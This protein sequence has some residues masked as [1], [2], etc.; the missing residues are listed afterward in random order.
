MYVIESDYDGTYVK[1][2]QSLKEGG[3]I[4]GFRCISDSNIYYKPFD[5][6]GNSNTKIY[7]V[8]RV[9]KESVKIRLKQAI[10]NNKIKKVFK[11]LISTFHD[12][13]QLILLQ[14]RFNE[15]SELICGGMIENGLDSEMNKIKS[16]LFDIVD[17]I[18]D[19]DLSTIDLFKL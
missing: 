16:S 8:T 14:S 7:K 17:K 11:S 5:I 12:D 15:L 18:E 19:E 13:K 4:I 2:L 9:I 1:E 3:K 6:T 10:G